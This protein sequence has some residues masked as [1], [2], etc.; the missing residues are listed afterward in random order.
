MQTWLLGQLISLCMVCGRNML[1]PLNYIASGVQLL[2]LNR[3]SMD[4]KA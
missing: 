3:Q 1:S 4:E 2:V